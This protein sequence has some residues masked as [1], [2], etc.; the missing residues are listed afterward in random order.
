LRRITPLVSHVSAPPQISP[1]ALSPE[2]SL[3][4]AAA[5]EDSLD[6]AASGEVSLEQAVVAGE[7]SLEQEAACDVMAMR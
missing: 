4:Q 2:S 1:P 7:V 6:Q 5:D 3:E